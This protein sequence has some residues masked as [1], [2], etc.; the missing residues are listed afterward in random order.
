MEYPLTATLLLGVC[1]F[2]A[3]LLHG[4]PMRYAL[5][6]APFGHA[7]G[8]RAAVV[9]GIAAAVAFPWYVA[10]PLLA[11]AM[12]LWGRAAVWTIY[13]AASMAAYVPELR[14]I[15]GHGHE[16]YFIRF[17]H[18]HGPHALDGPAMLDVLRTMDHEGRVRRGGHHFKVVVPAGENGCAAEGQ[19][20][21]I[22]DGRSVRIIDGPPGEAGGPADRAAL[23]EAYARMMLEGVRRSRGAPA[24]AAE[25]SRPPCVVIIDGHDRVHSALPADVS[26]EP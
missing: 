21:R 5:H 7:P 20:I 9:L 8:V 12:P 10:Q 16:R 18:A 1:A 3:Y 24:D 17:R 22:G 6:Q 19:V 15:G 23:D 26:G 13:A 14:A 11:A 2:G 4:L 25:G